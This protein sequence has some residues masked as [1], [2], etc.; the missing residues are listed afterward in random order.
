MS[1]ELIE[2]DDLNVF[3]VAG[4]SRSFKRKLQAL[5]EEETK[6]GGGAMQIQEELRDWLLAQL[7]DEKRRSSQRT[8]ASRALWRAF[9]ALSAAR[10]HLQHE[11]AAEEQVRQLRAEVEALWRQIS[12]MFAQ[13]VPAEGVPADEGVA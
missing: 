11:P 3:V 5:V 2:R 10:Y 7:R 8:P 4:V 1:Q 6:G 12:P 9:S 13:E